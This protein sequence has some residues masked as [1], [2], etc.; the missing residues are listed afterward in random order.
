MN[1]LLVSQTL[2][3]AG[4]ALLAM[5]A[6]AAVPS[7]KSTPEVAGQTGLKVKTFAGAQMMS[8]LTPKS[9]RWRC[10]QGEK[11]W[12]EEHFDVRE[13]WMG[14][15][16][17]CRWKDRKGNQLV[18]ATPTAFCPEFADNHAK[19]ADIDAKMAEGAEA[20]AEPSDETFV[21]WAAEFSDAKLE[22][23]ALAPLA[24][25]SLPAVRLVDF[26]EF[27]S[28]VAAFFKTKNGPWRYAEISLAQE[29]SPKDREALMK[30]FLKGVVEDKARQGGAGD[31]GG[32]VTEGRWKT[33]PVKDGYRFKTDLSLSQ[34]TA[35]IKNASRL[36]AAMQAAY[37]RYVP[38]QKEIGVSTV[39]VFAT[40]EGY[41]EYM[42]GATGES[43]ERSIGLWS[44]SHDELLILDMG[45]SA[46]EETLKTMRHEAF[47][48]Y[49]SYATGRARHAVWFNE[50]HACFFEN[51]SY[52]AK[53]NY[54]RVWD[55]PNDRR[56][57]R[58]AQEPDRFARLFLDIRLLDHDAFYA[59][60][61]REVNDRYAAAWA[62]VYFLEKG[63]PAFPEF[64]AYRGVLPAYL[65]AIADGKS[66]DE[67]TTIAWEPVAKRDFAADFTKFWNKRTGARKYEPLAK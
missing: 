29:S 2:A 25:S 7:L 37:R 43:G 26:G 21:R 8:A 48:Q 15:E 27:S 1:N 35:F 53:R 49:L 30:A 62:A 9:Q 33:F 42:K 32:I 39:R 47:H 45:N 38:P 6:M 28:R 52:D 10:R 64:A 11:T 20:F 13:I 63:A 61:L 55:D 31:R 24:V 3:M 14:H 12:I 19:R 67:A 41:N 51:V 65:K 44:P 4:C 34:G 56:P 50:G 23:S 58:V 46:R 16:C 54:V 59:G 22:A 17:S 18:L 36:M 40:R 60:T 66:P 5:R 57:A